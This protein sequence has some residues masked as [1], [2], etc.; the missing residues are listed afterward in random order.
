MSEEINNNEEVNTEAPKKAIKKK[1]IVKSKEKIKDLDLSKYGTRRQARI[2]AVMAL[3]SY[4]IN[5]KK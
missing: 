1:V 2:Y 5:E 4:E 3:Y